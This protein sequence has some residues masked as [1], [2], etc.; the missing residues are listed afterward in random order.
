MSSSAFT[1]LETQEAERELTQCI[2]SNPQYPQNNRVLNCRSSPD[3]HKLAA[4]TGALINILQSPDPQKSFEEMH[5]WNWRHIGTDDR[6]ARGVCAALANNAHV[7][8][9]NL[10]NTRLSSNVKLNYLL[11]A[12]RQRSTS[13]RILNLSGNQF[14]DDLAG[15]FVP[16]KNKSSISTR[17]HFI[18]A[19]CSMALKRVTLRIRFLEMLQLKT[20]RDTDSGLLAHGS[21]D[22]ER[23]AKVS[24][25]A[26]NLF[27]AV[28]RR[29]TRHMCVCGQP[30]YHSRRR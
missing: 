17:I 4:Y 29:R 10:V 13:L 28:E 5:I 7:T 27:E 6:H 16:Q 12:L 1:C 19:T 9:L 24:C 25:C 30:L 20:F 8:H 26:I 21:Q 2:L 23:L 18:Y 3:R 14:G 15:M 22:C 11:E